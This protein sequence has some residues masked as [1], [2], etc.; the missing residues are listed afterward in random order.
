LIDLIKKLLSK[1]K[2]TTVE[3]IHGKLGKM[4]FISD[5]DYW[6]A[7]SG[8]VFHAVP[9][10][11]NG[12]DEK[13]VD[14]I[15]SKREKIEYYWKLC[16]EELLLIAHEWCSIDKNLTAKEL[17]KVTGISLNVD[18][19]SDWE[20]CFETKPN[21]KWIHIGLYIKDDEIVAND[22]TT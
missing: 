6:E 11:E 16:S 9:G 13:A 1:T 10:D 5:Y 14:F 17:F 8:D 4:C 22:I 12:P 19:D 20:I 21:N 7:D 2:P 15:L 18:K 3:I